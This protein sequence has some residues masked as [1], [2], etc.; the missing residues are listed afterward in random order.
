MSFNGL[1]IEYALEG[2]SNY[3][4]RKDNVT[5]SSHIYPSNG[6]TGVNMSREDTN[7]RFNLLADLKEVEPT[8]TPKTHLTLH[9]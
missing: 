5:P 8:E 6:P 2:N 4:T 3:I 7:M 9:H 1:R